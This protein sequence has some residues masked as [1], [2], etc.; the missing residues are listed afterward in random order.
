MTRRVAIQMDPIASIKP[1]T[2]STLL[3]GIEAQRRGYEVYYYTPDKLAYY[4]GAVT[5]QAH[6]ITLRADPAHYYDLGETLTLDLNTM[7]VVLLRQDPPFDAAYIGTTYL[8]ERLP[9]TLVVNNPASVRDFPEKWAPTLFSQ[10]MP[11]TLIT[12]DPGEIERFRRE[13]K[14]IVIKPL[15]GFGGHNVFRIRPEDENFPT[16]MEMAF[17][18]SKEPWVAQP[19][20]PEVKTGERRIILIDGELAG[21]IGRI[22]LENEIRANM[23]VGGTAVKAELTSRQREICAAL[24]P[25]LKEKGLIL[26]GIDVIGDWLTEINITSPTGLAA[27][28][29]L[30]GKTL[31]SEVWDAIEKKL[32]SDYC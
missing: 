15:Y 13:H 27:I 16:L 14:D 4:N 6:R 17:G 18:H 19:F 21:V 30:Y 2:D 7:D 1:Q 9:K 12:A 11:P 31:E 22:P 23:R 5:A 10:Y 8:L 28:N 26:V 32:A 20:L 29:R 3:L 25:F 24:K